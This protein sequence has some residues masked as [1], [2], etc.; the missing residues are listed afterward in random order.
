MTTSLHGDALDRAMGRALELAAAAGSG[1][2]R[3]SVPSSWV[4]TAP[5]WPRP[6]TS[7]RRTA[8]PPRTPRCWRCG[9]RPGC[10]ATAGG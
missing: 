3:R 7:G 9:P 4:P 5:C 10:T 2:T 1:A 8:T 6:P